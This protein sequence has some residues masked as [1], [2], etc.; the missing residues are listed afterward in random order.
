[1]V[2][3]G[4][5]GNLKALPVFLVKIPVFLCNPRAGGDLFVFIENIEESDSRLRGNFF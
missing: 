5:L 2:H 1:M 3:C 4:R